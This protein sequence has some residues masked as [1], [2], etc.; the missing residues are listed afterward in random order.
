MGDAHAHYHSLLPL[1]PHKLPRAPPSANR[2]GH[3]HTVFKATGAQDGVCYAVRRV[4]AC[5]M[6]AEALQVQ[7]S[8]PVGGYF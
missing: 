6:N 1:E 4:E 5:R 8:R 3:A 2:H 7:I